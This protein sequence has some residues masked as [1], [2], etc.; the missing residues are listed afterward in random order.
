[1]DRKILELIL[2]WQNA[3]KDLPRVKSWRSPGESSQK[4]S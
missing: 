2:S 4:A 3:A 1:M